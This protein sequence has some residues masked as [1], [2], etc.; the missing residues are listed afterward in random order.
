MNTT[1]I[2]HV[3]STYV[4][5]E[6]SLTFCSRKSI[7]SDYWEATTR[8]FLLKKVFLKVY[9]DSQKNMCQNLFFDKM[10]SGT[11]VSCEFCKIF[12]NTIFAEHPRAT[13]SDYTFVEKK[14]QHFKWKFWEKITSEIM[15]LILKKQITSFSYI[16]GK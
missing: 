15:V 7:M 12:K 16:K 3:H 1:I 8:G 5:Q 10:Y 14:R 13:A 4:H 2:T 9:Q 6:T 11:G